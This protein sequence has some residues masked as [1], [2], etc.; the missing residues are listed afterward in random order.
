[1]LIV[2]A[3]PWREKRGDRLLTFLFVALIVPLILAFLVLSFSHKDDRQTWPTATAH[4]SGIRIVA[5][6]AEEHAFASGS[7]LYRVEAHV[8]FERKGKPVD[9]WAPASEIKRDKAYLESW[10]AKKKQD[11]CLVRWNPKN[12]DDVEAVLTDNVARNVSQ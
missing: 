12:P 9:R 2:R 11:S 7:I 3:K 1:M 8:S 6:A 10:L 4:I 5:V